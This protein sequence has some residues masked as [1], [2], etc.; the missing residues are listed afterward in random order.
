MKLAAGA[1]SQWES[2]DGVKILGQLVRAGLMETIEIRKRGYPFRQ[3]YVTLWDTFQET[4]V[5]KML[6]TSQQ[7]EIMSKDEERDQ[8]TFL[9][10][11]T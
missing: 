3:S 10:F 2:F 7:S 5:L 9:S 11:R 1:D 8:C 4:G 6:K